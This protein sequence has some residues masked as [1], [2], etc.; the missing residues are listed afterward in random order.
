MVQETKVEHHIF[1]CIYWN[2]VLAQ[3]IRC[4]KY[5]WEENIK[6]DLMEIGLEVWIGFIWLKIGTSGGFCGH[7]NEPSGSLKGGEFL[8]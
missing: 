3:K 8:E 7:G 4:G 5:G 1:F 6:M 2:L